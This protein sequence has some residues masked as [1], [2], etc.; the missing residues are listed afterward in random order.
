[1]ITIM[2][3]NVNH[4]ICSIECCNYFSYYGGTCQ[5]TISSPE[6]IAQKEIK[7]LGKVMDPYLAAKQQL[8]EYQNQLND[9][10]SKSAGEGVSDIKSQIQKLKDSIKRHEAQLSIMEQKSIEKYKIEPELEVKLR[11]AQ[12]EVLDSDLPISSVSVSGLHKALVVTINE[13]YL[14]VEKDKAYYEQLIQD[15]YSDLPVLVRFGIIQLDGCATPQSNCDPLLGGIQMQA[16]NNGKCT[17]G[18]P[19]DRNGTDGFITAAHCVDDLPGSGDDIFQPTE[20]WLGWNKIGDVSVAL[21]NVNCDCAWIDQSSSDTNI[22]A[23]WSNIHTWTNIVAYVD[24]PVQGTYV[25]LHG[26]T[27]NLSYGIVDDPY[28]DSCTVIDGDYMC[29]DAVS[30]TTD[31][32]QSGDSGGTYTD[33]TQ[34]TF[35][36]MHYSSGLGASYFGPWERIEAGLDL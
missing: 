8:S 11:N 2:I 18:L 21:L 27:S 5:Y 34:S 12:Q 26:A 35:M 3:R 13:T 17:I 14:T 31:I 6:E 15:K 4:A 1:M 24:R 20:D 7:E 28:R 29:I 22:S 25:I 16:K 23:V 9:A 10:I 36:G 33:Y 32:S 30:T 19:I